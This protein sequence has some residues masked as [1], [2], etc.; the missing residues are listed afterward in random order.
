MWVCVRQVLAYVH[1]SKIA[2]RA[3]RPARAS[4]SGF[5]APLLALA[6]RRAGGL[7]RD[8]RGARLGHWRGPGRPAPMVGPA[9][10]KDARGLATGEAGSGRGH[11]RLRLAERRRPG[12]MVGAVEQACPGPA[13]Q[14]FRLASG[15]RERR[16]ARRACHA[17]T[18]C[19]AAHAACFRRRSRDQRDPAAGPRQLAGAGCRK[20]QPLRAWQGARKNR[21]NAERG[22]RQ[23][24]GSGG[25]K[26]QSAR[27]SQDAGRNPCGSRKMGGARVQAA[28]RTG[29]GQ[30]DAGVSQR[31]R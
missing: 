28:R 22:P 9:Q 18:R 1:P 30:G 5:L 23:V 24:A 12:P 25:A 10:P 11:G 31:P 21:G 20:A 17:V 27:A 3:R 29:S 14:P 15:A 8:M 13:R 7:G 2:S 4:R 16:I 26:E 19:L 6:A